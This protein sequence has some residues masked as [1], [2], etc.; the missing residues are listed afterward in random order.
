MNQGLRKAVTEMVVLATVQ[1]FERQNGNDCRRRLLRNQPF[2]A[3]Q[4]NEDRDDQAAD[5]QGIGIPAETPDRRSSRPIVQAI[6]F[7]TRRRQ[8]E[9]PGEDQRDRE[10]DRGENDQQT[11]DPGRRT[12]RVEDHIAHLQHQ[13]RDDQVSEPD[14]H[15]ATAP[16]AIPER[17]LFRRFVHPPVSSLAGPL[18][19]HH[20]LPAGATPRR[21]DARKRM[22]AVE[23]PC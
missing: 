21:L 6:D 8:F 7:D 4:Q 15:D 20:W 22:L 5:D 17:W 13:P 1:F 23:R 2:L 19:L 9:E 10:T 18:A 14:T 12:E 16:Q 11:H 3:G